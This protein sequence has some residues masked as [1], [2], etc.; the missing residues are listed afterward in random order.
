M[1]YALIKDNKVVQIDCSPREGFIEVEDS[2]VCGMLYDGEHF[3]P[4]Q[5]QSQS[6][7]VSIQQQI[8]DLESQ[9]TPR[10]LREATMGQQYALDKLSEIDEAITYLRDIS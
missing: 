3:S 10:L 4:P 8:L 9:Q 1:R 6:Q 2:I 5:S 7:P